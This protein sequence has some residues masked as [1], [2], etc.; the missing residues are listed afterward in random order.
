MKSLWKDTKTLVVGV[1]TVSVITVTILMTSCNTEEVVEQAVINQVNEV[2]EELD[3]KVEE[4]K[5][6]IEEIIPEVPEIPEVNIKE[7]INNAIEGE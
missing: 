2:K 3:I 7:T 1:C 5:S 6:N 4:V